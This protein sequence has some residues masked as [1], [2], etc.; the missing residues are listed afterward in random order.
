VEHILGLVE[1]NLGGIDAL[2]EETMP[3][4]KLERLDA[5]DRNILRIGIAELLYADE[6]P[7]KVAIHEAIRLAGRYGSEESSRFVNGVLDAVHRK[8]AV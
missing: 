5:I 8:V 4:W 2:L 6:I 3:N 1:A 7:P